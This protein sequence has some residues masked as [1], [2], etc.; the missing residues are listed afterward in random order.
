MKYDDFIIWYKHKIKKRFSL[1]SKKMELAAIEF[2]LI[3]DL[4]RLCFI[5]PPF[6]LWALSKD[7]F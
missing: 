6:L 7:K 1:S 4:Y 5:P 2:E 3:I